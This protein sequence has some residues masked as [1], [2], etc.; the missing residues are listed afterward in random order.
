MIYDRIR[1][2]VRN[3]NIFVNKDYSKVI[4]MR[5]TVRRIKSMT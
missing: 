1:E 4:E 3:G 5:G 2:K